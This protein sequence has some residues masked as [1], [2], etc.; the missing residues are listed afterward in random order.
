MAQ[1]A[2]RAPRDQGGPVVGLEKPDHKVL[3][4]QPGPQV[5]QAPS[6]PPD[7]QGLKATREVRGQSAKPDHPV[8]QESMASMVLTARLG[9][10]DQEGL[11]VRKVSQGLR[12]Q[13]A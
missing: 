13:M 1:T 2:S 7:Q 6:A 12:A 3:L 4:V 11:V 10:Q 8:L 9:P 5:Q